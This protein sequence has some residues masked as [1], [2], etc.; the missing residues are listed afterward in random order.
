M[1]NP[2]HVLMDSSIYRT[3]P[4][5]TTAGFQTMTRLAVVERI[6]LHL[7]HYV[8]EEF[9]T[10]QAE[11]ISVKFGK[12]K[13]AGK[14]VLELTGQANTVGVVERI[15]DKV[16]VLSSATMA[17]AT[18]EFDGW[19]DE[20]KTEIHEVD[21][22]HGKRVTD[23]YFAGND[24]FE[25]QKKRR[26]FPDAFIYQTVRDLAEQHGSLHVIVAD[27]NLRESCERLEKVTTHHNIRSFIRLPECQMLIREL[28]QVLNISQNISR[29]IKLL[30]QETTVLQDNLDAQIINILPGTEIWLS[31][32]QS[33]SNDATV[34]SIGEQ[35]ETSFQFDDV[36]YYGDGEIV[37]P[38]SAVV[39]CAISYCIYK[40]DWYAIKD[41]EN[42]PHIS[43]TD[44]NK[45]YVL[46]EETREIDVKGRLILSLAAN[47]LQ[48]EDVSE[49]DLSD[50]I[51]AAG[52][53][54][55]IE[56]AGE[57]LYHN[58]LFS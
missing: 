35:S 42:P 54:V 12:M 23:A 47:E 33:D 25:S 51:N 13:Q 4:K 26:D 22:S 53:R 5:R 2:M 8:R 50:L 38:F 29:I 57:D 19:I 21:D 9:L 1:K 46:A 40:P 10:Q 7:P 15:L 41:L 39:E 16:E 17:I 30:P 32:I 45:H 11:K 31:D 49:E 20:T 3:D 43:A 6:Q 27:K 28:D 48:Q 18:K 55:E 56:A 36:E 34:D 37:V 52:Y 58:R 44:W 14:S 24:P